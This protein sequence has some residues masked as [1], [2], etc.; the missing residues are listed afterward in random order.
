MFIKFNNPNWE[1]MLYI[2]IKGQQLNILYW[3]FGLG[4]PN[5]LHLKVCGSQFCKILVVDN[6]LLDHVGLPHILD[7]AVHLINSETFKHPFSGPLFYGPSL[8]WDLVGHGDLDLG[9]TVIISHKRS[10]LNVSSKE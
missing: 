6:L 10:R 7:V 1:F 8:T 3:E 4:T 2:I 9:L 5:C